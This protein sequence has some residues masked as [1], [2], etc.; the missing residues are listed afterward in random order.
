MADRTDASTKRPLLEDET[1]ERGNA[2]QYPHVGRRAMEDSM[3]RTRMHANQK[4]GCEGYVQ[5]LLRARGPVIH[6]RAVRGGRLAHQ[7]ARS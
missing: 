2:G 4:D 3:D 7:L 6:V 1:H 5:M